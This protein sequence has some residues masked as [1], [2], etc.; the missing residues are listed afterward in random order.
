MLSRQDPR[1]LEKHRCHRALGSPEL[2]TGASRAGNRDLQSRGSGSVGCGLL[3][4]CLA[5]PPD[6]KSPCRNRH[7]LVFCNLFRYWLRAANGKELQ[8]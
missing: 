7:A 2:G 5:G 8:R 6:Y 1:G 3:T 4:Q